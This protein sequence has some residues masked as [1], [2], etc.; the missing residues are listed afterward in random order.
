MASLS[1]ILYSPLIDKI[2]S[3]HK[4]V[5][6]ALLTSDVFKGEVLGKSYLELSKQP[7]TSTLVPYVGPLSIIECAQVS[8]L[9]E[10]HITHNV[11]RLRQFWLGLLP[12]AHA[13][14]IYILVQLKSTPK[15]QSLSEHKLI[16]EA[17]KLQF[18][19]VPSLHTDV[20]VEKESLA[21][22]EGAMFEKSARTGIAGHYQWGLDARE[23]QSDRRR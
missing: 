2:L 5:L 13:Y 15:Y 8:D 3:L 4:A 20:D 16:E 23:H 14:T 17:Q 19:S 7:L 18:S 10:H 12:I 6:I 1:S 21:Q 11:K 9:F 22:L